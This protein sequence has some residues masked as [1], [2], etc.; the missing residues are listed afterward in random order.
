EVLQFTQLQSF[1]VS[2]PPL[3]FDL[4]TIMRQPNH[5]R[6]AKG[7]M[8]LAFGET[9][10]QRAEPIIEEVERL[11]SNGPGPLLAASG[12]LLSMAALLLALWRR[13]R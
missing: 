2:G 5:Y 12:A 4:A 13:Y 3:P 11:R 8:R 9:P 7:I 6:L 10:R 1:A